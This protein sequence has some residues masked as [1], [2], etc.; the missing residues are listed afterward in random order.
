MTDRQTTV[1]TNVAGVSVV[2]STPTVDNTITPTMASV[3]E[4]ESLAAQAIQA[5]V[6][7]NHPA[8]PVDRP[9]PREVAPGTGVPLPPQTTGHNPGETVAIPGGSHR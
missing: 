1:A 6:N 7:T 4:A 3:A 8:T 5:S 2:T 9:A